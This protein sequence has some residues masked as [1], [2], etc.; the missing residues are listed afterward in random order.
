VTLAAAGAGSPTVLIELGAV[1][2]LLALAGRLADRIGISPIPLY[3]LAG[4]T[5]GDGGVVELVTAR[6]FIETG[7]QIGVVLLLL[8]LGLEYSGHELVASLHTNRAAGLVDLALNATPGVVVALLLGWSATAA[9]FLGGITYISSSG[10]VSKL[11]TELGRV[12]NRET[13]TILSILITEDLVMALFLPVAAGLLVA[14]GVVDTL[15][16]VAVAG[17][18]VALAFVLTLRFGEHMSAVVFTPSS[19]VVLLTLIGIALVVAGSAEEIHAPAAV[20]ALLVGIALSGPAAD[21]ARIVLTPLRDLFAAVFFVFFGL[22]IDPATLLPVLPLA[23]GLAVVSAATKV[24]TGSWAARRAAIALPGRLRA[25]TAL[26]ARGEFSI[27]IAGLALAGGL[28]EPKLGPLAATYVLILATAG[29]LLTRFAD[30]VAF[31]VLRARRD[32]AR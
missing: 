8:M 19:E 28:D 4:L 15:V 14:T 13:P 6:S 27:I 25:G 5:V 31:A 16:D 11:L 18:A 32:R 10:I 29:P 3:L 17:L 1:V 21:T 7:A 30:P 2:L 23:A 26:I 20:G 24:Y 12:G 22:E 9:V